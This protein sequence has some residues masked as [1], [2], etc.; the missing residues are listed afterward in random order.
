MMDEKDGLFSGISFQHAVVKS[1]QLIGMSS[2]KIKKA[3]DCELSLIKTSKHALLAFLV[4][5]CKH[6]V[7]SLTK[8]VKTGDEMKLESKLY[9]RS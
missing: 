6:Y 1:N 3:C 5:T 8:A 7:C 2:G 9:A 4:S